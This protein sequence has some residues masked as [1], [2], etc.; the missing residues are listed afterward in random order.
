MSV[1][2]KP[3]SNVAEI[4]DLYRVWHEKSPPIAATLFSSPMR[5]VIHNLL[6]M[7]RIIG[8]NDQLAILSCVEYFGIQGVFG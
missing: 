5:G 8:C 7:S 6:K 4:E 3:A 1:E 2:A